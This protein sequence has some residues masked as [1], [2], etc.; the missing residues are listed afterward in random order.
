VSLPDGELAGDIWVDDHGCLTP[1]G[2]KNAEELPGR[3][4][5]FGLVDAH[6]HPSLGDGPDGPVTFDAE[7]TVATLTA[8]SRQGVTVVRDVGSPGGLSLTLDLPQ[9]SPRFHAAGRFLAP[10]DQ[11]FPDLLPDAAP[12]VDLTELA[13]AEVARGARWVKIIADFPRVTDG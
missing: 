6:G 3:Y 10:A 2:D 4:A 8:W 11:Y 1:V 7:G 13:L 5:I 12:E 9:G